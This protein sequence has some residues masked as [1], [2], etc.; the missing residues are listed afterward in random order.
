[1]LVSF[2]QPISVGGSNATLLP[3]RV[4]Y[5]LVEEDI[6]N[7]YIELPLASI[8]IPATLIF[9]DRLLLSPELDYTISFID[10]KI[11][12][13]FVGDYSPGQPEAPSIGDNLHIFYWTTQ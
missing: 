8:I 10:G 12:I 11:R 6:N 13:S 5:T 4:N 9:V 2:L 3:F 1:M 7:N